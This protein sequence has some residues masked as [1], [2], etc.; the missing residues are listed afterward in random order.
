MALGRDVTLEELRRDFDAV[1]LGVGLGA[2]N[3]LGLPGEDELE[4]VVDAVDF[5]A[6][7][8][9]AQDLTEVPIGR[10]V[11]VIG[12]GMTAIDAAVQSKRLGAEMVTIVYRRGLDEMKA[13]RYEREL[14]QTSGVDDPPLGA[15]DRAGRPRR[16]GVR[17]RVRATRE[18]RR[19]RLARRGAPFRIEAD[20]CSP[21]SARAGRRTSLD[22]AGA[23]EIKDGQIVVDEERR[24]SLGGVWAGGDCV[25]GGL[26]LTVSAVE[27][28][29]RAARSIA[30][31]LGAARA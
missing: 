5:I 2:T 14:A 10:R 31:A 19:R 18:A 7:L 30:A 23:I 15:P 4:N 25:F 9:Q 6:D 3:K 24:T 27:D 11:V 12:G 28:G 17:R 22:G 8:R 20:V 21:R 26:D 16:R 1:F 29:K 13:S